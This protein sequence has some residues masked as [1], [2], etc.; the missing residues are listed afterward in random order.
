MKHA[1][2]PAGVVELIKLYFAPWGAAKAAVWERLT[3][4]RPFN[5]EVAMQTLS[6]MLTAAP[7][8]EPSDEEVEAAA[9]AIYNAVRDGV[10]QHL[11]PTHPYWPC[12]AEQQRENIKS[13][14]RVQ[15]RAALIEA[16]K[17]RRG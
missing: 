7:P 5:G 11:Q 2:V 14:C 1:V 10:S 17:A 16:D 8:Y 15:A 12:W 3:G 4:D 9:E 13:I 6:A